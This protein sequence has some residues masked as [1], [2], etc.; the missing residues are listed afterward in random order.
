M[1]EGLIM[2]SLL[3]AGTAAGLMVLGTVGVANADNMNVPSNSPYAV[4]GG[5]SEMAGATATVRC[6]DGSYAYSGLD[7]GITEGRSAFVAPDYYD[8]DSSFVDPGY[9]GYG[10]GG[11]VGGFGGGRHFGGGYFGGGGAGHFGGGHGGGRNK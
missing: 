8:G 7:C 6:A 4:M 9:G 10:Y 1:L 11:P 3:L 5:P 2:R